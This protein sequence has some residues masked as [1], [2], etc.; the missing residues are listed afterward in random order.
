MYTS[1]K[2]IIAFIPFLI[3]AIALS[4]FGKD[5]KQFSKIPKLDFQI[6]G[7]N[8][9]SVVNLFAEYGSNGREKYYL[10]TLLDIPFP[11]FV[12]LFGLSY[13][14]FTWKKWNY[15][16]LWIILMIACFS[17]L[18]FDCLENYFVIR[19]LN[20]FPKLNANEIN[21]S[22]LATQI[23]LISLLIIYLFIIITFAFQIVEFLRNKK[24]FS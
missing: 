9:N 5:L 21:I 6:K 14:G 12:A 8:I 15:K 3:N 4:V 20:K 23:K 19:M 17:F 22:S 24:S 7:Y 2:A 11:F 18:I 10:L 16:K 13:F 1:K